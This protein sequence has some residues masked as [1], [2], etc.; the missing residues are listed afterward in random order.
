MGLL[1]LAR[2]QPLCQVKVG[3]MPVVKPRVMLLLEMVVE[4]KCREIKG[5][6]CRDSKEETLQMP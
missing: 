2:H 1:H 4:H 6:K 5:H 3:M